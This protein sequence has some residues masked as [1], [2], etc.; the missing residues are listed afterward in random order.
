MKN[1]FFYDAPDDDGGANVG[2]M[3]DFIVNPE[4]NF[5][6]DWKASLGEDVRGS[7]EGVDTFNDMVTQIHQ[8]KTNPPKTTGLADDKGMLQENWQSQFPELAENASMKNFKS[9]E[10]MAKSLINANKMVG[11]KLAP[12]EFVSDEHKKEFYQSMGVPEKA[13]DYGMVQPENHPEGMP[14]DQEQVN[15]F[16]NQALKYNLTPEQTLGLRGEFYDMQKNAWEN[17]TGEIEGSL[18]AEREEL[19]TEW[20]DKY[21]HNLEMGAAALEKIDGF[22]IAKEFG[23][24]K[25]P[26]FAKFMYALSQTMGED[27]L[28]S[29]GQGAAAETVEAIKGKVSELQAHPG[30][31]DPSH[32]EYQ[33]IQRKITGYFEQMYPKGS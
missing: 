3:T 24:E 32:P 31:Q 19:K 5:A 17:G 2:T 9:I 15:W 16:A 29:I 27:S 13:E 6:S 11:K 23:L 7:M 22:E 30:Y 10:G 33:N 20:A 1:L 21:D 18:D 8:S 4:G 14:Y 28:V 26:K 25:I 12:G